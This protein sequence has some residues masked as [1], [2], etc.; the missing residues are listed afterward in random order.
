MRKKQ[1]R[2]VVFGIIGNLFLLFV[3][4]IVAVF[5]NSIAVISDALNSLID[6]VT[7]G[8]VY[9]CMK[10][11]KK[12]PD[13]THPFGHHRAEPIAAMLV[14]VFTGIIGI[15]VFHRAFLRMFDNKVL[16]IPLGIIFMYFTVVIVKGILLLYTNMANRRSTSEALKAL[17]VDHR[18][19]IFVSLSII[20][21]FF[22]VRMGYTMVDPILGMVVAVYILASGWE[23]GA[24]NIKY[25]MGA[26]PPER[27]LVKIKEAALRV[28]G[29]KG[30]NDVRAHYVGLL[31]NVEIHIELDKKLSLV[32][33]HD[34]GKAVEKKV[35]SLEEIERAFVHIDP[36]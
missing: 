36:L 26:S 34:I 23:I 17:A 25:L 14:A 1:K 5:T 31:L 9:V 28:N 32:K 19:D 27:L 15:E 7:S 10:I 18:N 6:V 4:I 33:A 24:R 21:G 2:A 29:V 35:Q 16:D 22:A 13:K 11:S 20:V 12:H 8:I 3:K 30:L